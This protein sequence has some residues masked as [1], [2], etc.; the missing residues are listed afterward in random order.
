M[1]HVYRQITGLTR[2]KPVVFAQKRE[3]ADQF[4]FE[5]LVLLPRP[6]T[7]ELRRFWMKTV[8]REPVRIYRSEARRID[9]ELARVNAAL[10]HVYFGHIG[11][12]LLPFIEKS[13]VPVIVS[14]H[15]ADAMVDMDKP[16]YRTLAGRVLRKANLILARSESLAERLVLLGADRTKIRIHR[17]GIPLGQFPFVQRHAPADGAWHFIQACRLISKKG[18][19][20]TLR[21]F[22]KFAQ[23][24]P[25]A[26]LT[27]AGE[28]PLLPE[29]QSAAGE[30][31]IGDRVRFAGFLDQE[32]LRRQFESAHAFVHPSEMGPDGNQEGVPNSM[33]EAMAMGLPALAT[34]HGGI[35]EAV[36]NGVSGTLVAEQDWRG[37]ADAM[38]RLAGAH[39][40]YETMSRAASEAVRAGF[41]QGVQ[42][43]VLED[44][45]QQVLSL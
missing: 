21:A 33:L 40:R 27:I 9:R 44:C 16:A 6:V 35:P 45:Y 19:Q 29:L 7:R 1:L 3:N 25:K 43:R 26:R 5:D 12:Y 15:G 18:L 17:T 20:T 36:E 13:Q 10:I 23:A 41:E 8:R 24:Y 34:T 22:A 14:F 4:P 38:T 30:M 28:G 11:V 2:F 42:I 39:S 31:G 32:S 37:L